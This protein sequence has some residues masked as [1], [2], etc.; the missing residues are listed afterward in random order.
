M[1]IY[2]IIILTRELRT[3]FSPLIATFTSSEMMLIIGSK[4]FGSICVG[5]KFFL[6]KKKKFGSKI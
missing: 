3:R 2:F 4:F 5:T 1:L 6:K